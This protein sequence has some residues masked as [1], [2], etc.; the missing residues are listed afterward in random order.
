MKKI[1]DAKKN[2][3]KKQAKVQKKAKNKTKTQALK[4]IKLAITNKKAKKIKTFK[5]IFSDPINK[6]ES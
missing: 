1:A 5:D 3:A 4:M 6:N 2:L